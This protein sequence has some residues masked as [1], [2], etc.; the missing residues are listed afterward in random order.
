MDSILV[1][2]NVL[3]K[4]AGQIDEKAKGYYEEYQLLLK[5]VQ[6]FTTSDFRGKDAKAFREKVQGFEEDFNKM[7]SLMDQYAGFL[8]NAATNYRNTQENLKNEAQRLR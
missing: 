5:D 7:K 1:S 3:E 2:P 8:R 6:D 4:V